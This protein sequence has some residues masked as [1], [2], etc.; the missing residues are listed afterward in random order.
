[1]T[2][3]WIGVSVFVLFAAFRV[4]FA[5]VVWV[6]WLSVVVPCPVVVVHTRGGVRGSESVA[7]AEQVGDVAMVV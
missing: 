6:W 7:V 5:L 4:L 2:V 1:M 3:T